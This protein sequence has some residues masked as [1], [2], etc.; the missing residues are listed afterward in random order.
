MNSYWDIPIIYGID[1]KPTSDELKHFGAAMASFGSTPMF[2]IV[3]TPEDHLAQNKNPKM[4]NIS[5]SDLNN[6][7]KKLFTKR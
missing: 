5:L 1:F 3:V 4:N 6:F 7:Y 2:H